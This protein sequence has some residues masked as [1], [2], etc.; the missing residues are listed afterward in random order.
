[1]L[2]P[3]D[4]FMLSLLIYFCT[5]CWCIVPIFRDV[6]PIGRMELTLRDRHR[7]LDREH[8]REVP[9]QAMCLLSWVRKPLSSAR[10]PNTLFIFFLCCNECEKLLCGG[11]D[12][13]R[14]SFFKVALAISDEGSSSSQA[15]MVPFTGFSCVVC[16]HQTI[17]SFL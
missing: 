6:V 9:F 14:Y 1:M 5:S 7:V 11:L 8:R 4:I 2:G 3:V 15:V 17:S 16:F 10:R 12:F 13:A